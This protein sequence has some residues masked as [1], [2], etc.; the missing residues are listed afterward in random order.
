MKFN[1]E[2]FAREHHKT[3]FHYRISECKVKIIKSRNTKT[4]GL[5]FGSFY[6]QS[7]ELI[8]R[9]HIYLWP[10]VAPRNKRPQVYMQPIESLRVINNYLQSDLI[11]WSASKANINRSYTRRSIAISARSAPQE[12]SPPACTKCPRENRSLRSPR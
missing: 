10:F 9:L 3:I 2:L 7:R 6:S 8:D 1:T 5:I 4:L 12:D 11:N